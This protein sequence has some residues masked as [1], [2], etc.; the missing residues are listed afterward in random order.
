MGLVRDAGERVA[1]NYTSPGIAAIAVPGLFQ[2]EEE[3]RGANFARSGNGSC[4]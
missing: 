2:V 1:V 4:A 3:D